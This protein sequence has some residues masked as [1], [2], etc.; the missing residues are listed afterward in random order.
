MEILLKHIMD[1]EEPSELEPL[2]LK[3]VKHCKV[4][5]HRLD[6]DIELKDHCIQWEITLFSC[7]ALD[8][9]VINKETI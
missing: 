9:P 7:D 1:L 6:I 4:N 8:E 3:T 2:V 5:I